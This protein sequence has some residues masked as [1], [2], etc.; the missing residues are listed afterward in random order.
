MIVLR[1]PVEL[2]KLLD[3]WAE[4]KGISRNTL[5]SRELATAAMKYQKGLT[6]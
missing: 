3:R 1:L 4:E 2:V 5:A 6:D